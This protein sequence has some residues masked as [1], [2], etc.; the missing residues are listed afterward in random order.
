MPLNA[1]NCRMHLRAKQIL[2]QIYVMQ[3]AYRQEYDSYWGNGVSADK[4][5]PNNFSRI[6]VTLMTSAR[7][8][9]A[10]TAAANTFSCTATANIDDDA[11]IDTWTIDDAG[12]LL[13]TIDDATT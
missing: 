2:K 6:G 1:G 3:Q 5:N 4:N 8:G 10:L 9:Y 12:T 13:N 7:Y 11:T